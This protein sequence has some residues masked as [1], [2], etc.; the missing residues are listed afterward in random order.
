MRYLLGHALLCIL[1]FSS[2]KPREEAAPVVSSASSCSKEPCEDPALADARNACLKISGAQW[3][4]E[5]QSCRQAY[6]LGTCQKLNKSLVWDGL[7][8]VPESTAKNFYRL[9]IDPNIPPSM[10]QTLSLIMNGF[11]GSGCQAVH[12]YL[13][14]QPKMVFQQM[15]MVDLSI[16]Q[17]FSKL[18]SLDL[19]GNAIQDL[20]PLA[21]LTQL[22]LLNLGHNAISDVRALTGLKKL[23]YLYLF[24]NTIK[25]ISPLASLK[26]LQLLDVRSNPVT[27]LSAISALNIKDLRTD[28]AP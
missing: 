11:N 1:V 20:S 14:E 26:S 24:E 8:C 21:S 18:K 17:S 28:L 25:D 15:G 19:W 10:Q 5:T 9:C 16:F 2:C 3:N 27:D 13:S 6:S 23:K 12:A 7:K 4:T 22:E